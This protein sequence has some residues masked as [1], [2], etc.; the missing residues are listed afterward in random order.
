MLVTRLQSQIA[1]DLKWLPSWLS[2]VS[3]PSLHPLKVV[4]KTMLSMRVM[5]QFWPLPL[6]M[7]VANSK[8]WRLLPELIWMTMLWTVISLVELN[9]VRGMLRQLQVILRQQVLI[10]QPLRQPFIWRMIWPILLVTH[11]SVMLLLLTMRRIWTVQ[12]VWV[13]FVWRRDVLQIVRQVYRQRR[14][15]RWQA[16]LLWQRQIR[17]R[18]LRLCQPW[19]QKQLIVLSLIQSIM[20][21]QW[22]LLIRMIRQIPWRCP[23]LI[24][25]I[26][27]L[28]L[29]VRVN[30]WNSQHLQVRP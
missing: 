4:E 23:C 17:V 11:G 27:S 30:L 22:Q 13:K 10:Q 14:P 5:M 3:N 16:W 1:H 15:F 21:A 20:M 28:F 6:R 8:K 29:I 18:L 2:M 26:A 19:T 12:M 9:T 24:V 25:T 7:I